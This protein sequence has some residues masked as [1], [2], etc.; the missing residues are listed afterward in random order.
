MEVESNIIQT[1][2]RASLSTEID[3]LRFYWQEI[4]VHNRDTMNEAGEVMLNEQKKI[5]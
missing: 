4:R 3:Q 5:T 1:G 2:Q